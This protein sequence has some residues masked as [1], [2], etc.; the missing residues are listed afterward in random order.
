MRESNANN[1]GSVQLSGRGLFNVLINL[2]CFIK[3]HTK[4]EEKSE[5]CIKCGKTLQE[6]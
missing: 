2:M 1:I 5:S 4:L 6:E 3:G